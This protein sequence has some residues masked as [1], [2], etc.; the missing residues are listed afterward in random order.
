LT[1]GAEEQKNQWNLRYDDSNFA[2][3][4]EEQT[5]QRKMRIVSEKRRIQEH[6]GKY[7]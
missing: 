2:M 4:R 3:Q 6:I 7:A 5:E 1:R